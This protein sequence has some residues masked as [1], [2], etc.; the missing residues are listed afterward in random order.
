MVEPASISIY[1][2][3]TSISEHFIVSVLDQRVLPN[4]G[5]CVTPSPLVTSSTCNR[6]ASPSPHTS[7]AFH[8]PRLPL[9]P[10]KSASDQRQSG[11]SALRPIGTFHA[12]LY[13]EETEGKSTKSQRVAVHYFTSK[14]ESS[15]PPIEPQSPRSPV[16]CSPST[17]YVR[18]QMVHTGSIRVVGLSTRSTTVATITAQ[19]RLTANDEPL[20]TTPRRR[21]GP[22]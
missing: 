20:R 4:N 8:R 13:V 3:V 22:L 19:P 17:S 5:P 2:Y 18:W 6:L 7:P 11:D 15:T 1:H 10:G 16:E 12:Q 21:R 9:G 14:K